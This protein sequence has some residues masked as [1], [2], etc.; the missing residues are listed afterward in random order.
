[1]G[2]RQLFISELADP[3][4]ESGA[5]YVELFNNECGPVDLSNYG[6]QRF[7][8]GNT[9][10]QEVVPLWGILDAKTAA[11]VSVNGAAFE[12]VFGVPPTIEVGE[13]GGPTDSNGRSERGGKGAVWMSWHFS[14]S[15]V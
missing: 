15:L 11:V 13:E 3:S 14:H 5:R 1:M 8:N 7:T 2:A 12:F 6:L 10:P 9:E 4:N